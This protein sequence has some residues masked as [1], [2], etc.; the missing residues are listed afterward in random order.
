MK[1]CLDIILV[2][3][4]QKLS[5]ALKEGLE[6][7]KK[8]SVKYKTDNGKDCFSYLQKNPIDAILMD[9]QIKGENGIQVAINIRKEFP[10][11]AIVFYSIQDDDT[12]FREFR[13][14]GILSHYAYVKKSNF[15]L[16]SQIIPLLK[17]AYQGRNF[18]DPEVESRVK[19]IKYS[20]ENS[21][22]SL[23]EPRE[24]EVAKLLSLG[25]SNEQISKKLNLKDKRSVSRING[26]IYSL[27]GLDSNTLDE[28]VARSRA[29]LIFRENKLFQWKDDYKI[30]YFN[31]HGNEVLWNS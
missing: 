29:I 18:I 13:H 26:Q 17:D 2:E 14:S 9:V 3:D 4:N 30:V 11:K 22:L 27:W 28:K 31:E 19:E 25:Y 20:D 8:I 21:P 5:L 7:T 15:L 23:L 1:D 24:L 6:N 16:P 12:Y 10:R